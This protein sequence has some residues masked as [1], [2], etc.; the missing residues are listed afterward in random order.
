MKLSKAYKYRIYPDEQQ[1]QY[2]HKHIGCSRYLYNNALEYKK[3][4][5]DRY[6]KNVRINIDISRQLTIVKKTEGLEF[7]SEV[8]SSSLIYALRNLET[9]YSNFFKGLSSFPKYRKK[10]HNKYQTYRLKLDQEKQ[11]VYFHKMNKP[12]K[13]KLHRNI[14]ENAK[15]N[16]QTIERK[17]NRYYISFSCEIEISDIE[18]KP[19]K[20]NTTIGID[21]GIKDLL[22]LSN[23]E[24]IE[25]KKYLDK[26]LKKLKRENRRLSRKQKGG[27]NWKKQSIKIAK[28]HDD[29]FNTRNDYQNK[30]ADRLTKKYDTICVEDLNLKGLIKNKKL[31]RQF[32]DVAIGNLFLKIQNKCL[33][34]G[35]NI[36]KID[37]FEPTSKTCNICGHKLK[38]LKLSI[39][40][41]TCPD[42]DI[43]HDRDINAAINIKNFGLKKLNTEATPEINACGVAKVQ[44][45]CGGR[46]RSRNTIKNNIVIENCL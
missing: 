3:M 15:Y 13:I 29:I 42:C 17:G 41:W 30:I 14:P 45:K 35:K 20:E 31:S 5:Y 39:R 28:L 22:I 33:E 32:S 11:L 25:N 38:E 27:E 21:A 4:M 37:K 40:N 1:K 23:G 34:R 43:K 2:I 36:I 7:L 10:T 12:V 6:K 26:N 8:D 9:A 19:V 46:Q 16:N 44:L 24:K 18:I